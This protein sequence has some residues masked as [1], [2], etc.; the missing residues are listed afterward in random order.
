VTPEVNE[1]LE[2]LKSKAVV[3]IVGGSACEIIDQWKNSKRGNATLATNS[4]IADFVYGMSIQFSGLIFL[5]DCGRCCVLLVFP[6]HKNC[7]NSVDLEGFFF[8]GIFFC[9]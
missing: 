8:V 9:G 4:R 1:F 7:E 5:Y 6:H 3:G 2:R